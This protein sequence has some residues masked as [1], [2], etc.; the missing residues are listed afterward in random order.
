MPGRHAAR[1]AAEIVSQIPDRA[2]REGQT[3]I[4]RA[5][6]GSKP[7]LHDIE[8]IT[9]HGN[10][11]DEASAPPMFD[12]RIGEESQDRVAPL[13]PQ[14]RGVQ[15]REAF[16]AAHALH[17]VGK[18]S[19]RPELEYLRAHRDSFSCARARACATMRA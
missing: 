11:V 2:S 8:E 1:F 9:L 17:D 14:H 3:R 12:H 4:A 18:R 15:E 7:L 5:I 13:R 10:A 19:E 16:L 6:A